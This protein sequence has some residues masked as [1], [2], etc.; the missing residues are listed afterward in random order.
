M[1]DDPQRDKPPLSAA[2]LELDAV[3]AGV[4]ADEITEDGGDTHLP[5]SDSALA[6]EEKDSDAVPERNLANRPPG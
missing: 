4:D 6:R 2:E 1:P 3:E 5:A